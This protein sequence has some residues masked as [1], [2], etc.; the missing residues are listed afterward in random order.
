M[1]LDT[2]YCTRQQRYFVY[3][4]TNA[5][6]IV[7]ELTFMDVASIESETGGV[8]TLQ[9][10]TPEG[11]MGVSYLT[12]NEGDHV[13]IENVNNAYAGNLSATDFVEQYHSV[14]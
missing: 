13:L 14:P 11:W 8:L 10:G 1:P 3:D 4:G 5:A 12:F 7:A 6:D 2:G 9:I